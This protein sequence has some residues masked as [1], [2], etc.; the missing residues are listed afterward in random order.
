MTDTSTKMIED[1]ASFYHVIKGNPLTSE[2]EDK[3]MVETLDNVFGERYRAA[4]GDGGSGI[5]RDRYF[6]FQG[7]LAGMYVA[8]RQWRHHLEAMALATGVD[9]ATGEPIKFHRE[10]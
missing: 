4:N 7:M 6:Y 2:V 5:G 1:A 8:R 3:E 10:F 9:P